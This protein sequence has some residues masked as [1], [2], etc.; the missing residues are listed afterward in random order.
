ME[1]SALKTLLVLVVCSAGVLLNAAS[2]FAQRKSNQLNLEIARLV[3]G[4]QHQDRA[5]I[6]MD[7]EWRRALARDRL[8]AIGSRSRKLR[9]RVIECLTAA[10]RKPD[11]KYESDWDGAC[12]VFGSLKATEAIDLLIERLGWSSGAS[13]SMSSPGAD[14]LIVIGQPSVP[15]LSEALL[16]SNASPAMRYYAT[17]ALGEIGGPRA[18]DALN[19]ALKVETERGIKRI[20][21][22]YLS[23]LTGS[24]STGP[25]VK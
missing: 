3:R 11:R 5:I 8:V 14:A 6:D 10:L 21:E 16:R 20:M 13:T 9:A 23:K 15:K 19:L 25:G 4:Q 12:R 17:V 7:R 18:R 2:S 22:E 24:L 1:N